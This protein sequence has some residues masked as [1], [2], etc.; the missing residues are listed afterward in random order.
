M[1]QGLVLWWVRRD[2][3]LH[4][5]PALRAA[6]AEARQLGLPLLC[7]APLPPDGSTR[8]GF[9]RLGPHRRWVEWQSLQAL[10]GQLRRH[11]QRLGWTTLTPA[12]AL[13]ELAA[14]HRVVA[15][16]AQQGLAPEEKAEEAALVAQGLPLHRHESGGLFEAAALPFARAPDT[17]LPAL[18]CSFTP[19]R[20]ALERSQRQPGSPLP[21]P[22]S[23]PPSPAGELPPP[24]LQ[25]PCPPVDPRSSHPY[26]TPPCAPGEAAA[27]Q[28]LEAYL[29]SPA[30][31]VYKK[32]RDALSDPQASTRW[33]P[34]LATGALSPRRAWA[35]LDAH[36]AAQGRSEGSDWIRVEL[37]WREYFRWLMAVEGARL[38]HPT[39]LKPGAAAPGHDAAAFERWCQGRTGL[40]LV[41]AG[42]R[43]LAATGWLSNRLRQVCASALLHELGGD[44]RAGAAWYEAQLLDFD[45]QSNQGNW[46][47]IAGYGTDPRGGRHFDLD[48]QARQHDPQGTYRA[49]WNEGHQP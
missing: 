17:G 10:D 3:R 46:A 47:Y 21:E 49:R 27:L 26:T 48:W 34:W 31:P 29:A 15:V 6:C 24:A 37:L 25:P 20:Q 13:G 44:W 5:N 23:W 1:R 8:W 43:E 16:H 28:H 38:Y 30:V 9:A 39:G 45:P 11:G 32:T 4:D 33:S 22:Q 2:Q 41:D 18:P 36:E 35:A 7:L 12:Q 14:R 19:F 40:P 42:M